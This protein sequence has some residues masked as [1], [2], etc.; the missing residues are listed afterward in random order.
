MLRYESVDVKN[1]SEIK[2]FIESNPREFTNKFCFSS[3]S[4]KKTIVDQAVKEVMQNLQN[5]V[6]FCARTDS[7]LK[8]LAI[9]TRSDWGSGFLKRK[10][11]ELALYVLLS[12][13]EMNSFLQTIFL[14]AAEMGFDAI[15]VRIDMAQMKLIQYILTKG[16]VLGD[17]LVTFGMSLSKGKQLE[18]LTVIGRSDIAFENGTAAHEEQ[19]GKI[20]V[21]A[22][23]HSHY[24][25][26]SNI[27][28]VHAERV[29]QEWIRNSLNGYANLVIVAKL[30]ERIVGYITLRIS[31]LGEKAYGTID[32]IAIEE[33]HRGHGIGRMLVTEAISRVRAAVDSIYVSTQVSNLAAMRL[34]QGLGF[35]PLLSEATLHFW[36]KS[37]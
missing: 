22:Y 21:N 36:L 14:K 8:A 35:E 5:G 10:M 18:S 31:K 24:F 13:G 29:Y 34:Y 28:L 25:N 37:L 11:G 26:D 3:P 2:A 16:A 23:K 6:G 1:G 15:F 30:K 9:M 32:L 17:I 19:L 12:E 4:E 7:R 20:T 27:P 33:R